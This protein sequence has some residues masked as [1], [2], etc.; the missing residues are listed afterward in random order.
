MSNAI[1][2]VKTDLFLN[3][4][5]SHVSAVLY[6]T[7]CWVH[8]PETPGAEFTI[9]HNPRATNPLADGWIE[10]GEEY[11]L[12]GSELRHTRHAVNNWQ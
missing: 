8:H 5:Y 11:W 6:S 7:S 9:V 12:D 3:H 4:K 2:I 10:L 1:E